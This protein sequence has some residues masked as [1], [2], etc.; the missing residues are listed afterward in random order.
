MRGRTHLVRTH[1]I[2]L[3]STMTHTLWTHNFQQQEVNNR[4]CGLP[5][6]TVLFTYPTYVLGILWEATL[7]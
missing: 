4:G 2:R 6:W 5:Q 3:E 7:A 1:G